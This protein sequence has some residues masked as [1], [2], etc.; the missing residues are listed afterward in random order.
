MK[1]ISKLYSNDIVI[2]LSINFVTFKIINLLDEEYET[3]GYYDSWA[4]MA[5]LY[6]GAVRNYYFAISINL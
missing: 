1:T 2:S 6:P 5:Y 3:A 4:G